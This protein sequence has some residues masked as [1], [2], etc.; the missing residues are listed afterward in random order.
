MTSSVPLTSI[1]T[2][3][4]D[5]NEP[6][7]K[8]FL[9]P[10]ETRLH[11]DM[12]YLWGMEM[13]TIDPTHERS[14][15]QVR[16]SMVTPFPGG[17]NSWFLVPTEETL[18]A[19]YELQMH[20]LDVP[21]SERI[22]FFD[23]FAEDEYEYIFVPRKTGVDFFISQPGLAPRRISAPY[24]D[25]PR[26]TS[27]ALPFFV[28]FDSQNKVLCLPATRGWQAACVNLTVHWQ[29]GELPE[30]FLLSCYPETLV[31]KS[32]DETPTEIDFSGSKSGS[33]ETIVT[34]EDDDGP[35][36][37]PDK[38]LYIHEWVESDARQSWDPVPRNIIP[39]TPRR[40]RT[41]DVSEASQKRAQWRVE[42]KRG[43]RYFE[44]HFPKAAARFR[45]TG[46]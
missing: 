6:L 35:L 19:M 25:F 8:K 37:F 13:G 12:E 26:V 14:I 16:K 10:A 43:L 44:R 3:L 45:A 21:V 20:N 29:P 17:A 7:A 30:D 41:R 11:R 24:T 34:P 22:S 9:F 1:A 28:A 4:E 5:F 33:D 46:S 42:S 36:F 38:K 40:D 27:S 18:N 2:S 15:L 31:T 32:D 23:E 39:P